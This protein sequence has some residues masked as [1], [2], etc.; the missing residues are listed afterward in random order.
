LRFKKICR[1]TFGLSNER[2]YPVEAVVQET[3]LFS[4]NAEPQHKPIKGYDASQIEFLMQN[5]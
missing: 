1:E 2:D 5:K 3:F 4:F